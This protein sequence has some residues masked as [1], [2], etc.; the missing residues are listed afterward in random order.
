MKI[1]YE[2]HPVTPER[3]VELRAQGFRILDARFA[4]ADEPARIDRDDI[5]KMK[6]G[7][8]VD[9]LGAHGVAES[10]CEGVK[11]GELRKRLSE[12]MFLEV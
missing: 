11:V 3:K 9:L 5:A 2:P 7:E 12:I 1:H 10:A 6:R 4:P 8:I